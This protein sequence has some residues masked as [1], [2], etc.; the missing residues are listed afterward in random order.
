M[1][2]SCSFW[3]HIV[4]T[5]FLYGKKASNILIQRNGTRVLLFSPHCFHGSMYESAQLAKL[6]LCLR[7]PIFNKHVL[8]RTHRQSAALFSSRQTSP[9]PRAAQQLQQ[10]SAACVLNAPTAHTRPAPPCVRVHTKIPSTSLS[11]ALVATR[12]LSLEVRLRASER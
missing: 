3:F 8:E 6:P 1:Y 5:F 7:L 11:H 10:Y 4:N 12:C 9:Q 2:R